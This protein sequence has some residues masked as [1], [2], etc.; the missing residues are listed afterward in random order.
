MLRTWSPPRL[1]AVEDVTD[2]LDGLPRESGW[3]DVVA[4]GTPGSMT[5]RLEDG[6]KFAADAKTVFQ[7][8]K[9]SLKAEDL[10][11]WQSLNDDT[12]TGFRL[13]S[14]SVGY[15]PTGIAQGLANQLGVPVK[16]PDGVLWVLRSGGR[17]IPVIHLCAVCKGYARGGGG[18]WVYDHV[19]NSKER[20]SW[21]VFKPST[22]EA[23]VE[24][25]DSLL[26]L[27]KKKAWW[28]VTVK[29]VR[30]DEAKIDEVMKS[31][32]EINPKLK[33]TGSEAKEVRERIAKARAFVAIDK[34]PWDDARKLVPVLAKLGLTA[35]AEP[36]SAW[37]FVFKGVK[38]D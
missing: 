23:D 4:H 18:A 9:K 29:R 34:L 25:R 30:V 20:G 37:N 2:A 24:L 1:V 16:A 10:A 28:Q 33:G 27:A 14:C 35:E 3:I 6:S 38:T 22:G 31:L 12:D 5:L 11:H 17:T 26:G 36:M 7:V 15:S 13:V 19:L 21:R 8:I 32:G